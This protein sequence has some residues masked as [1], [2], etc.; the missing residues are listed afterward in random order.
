[1]DNLTEIT[2][3]AGVSVGESSLGRSSLN[4]NLKGSS[5]GNMNSTGLSNI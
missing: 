1:M 2:T 5:V 4:R 3:A